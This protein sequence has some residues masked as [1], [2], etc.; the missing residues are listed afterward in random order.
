[1]VN[2]YRRATIILLI[3]ICLFFLF[4]IGFF[5]LIGASSKQILVNFYERRIGPRQILSSLSTK[6]DA[7][8]NLNNLE[9]KIL[10]LRAE[11]ARLILKLQESELIKEQCAFLKQ[12]KYNFVLS[13]IV[14][15]RTEAG[16]NWYIIN[17]GTKDNIK[18]GLA[19]I[20]NDGYLVGKIIKTEADYSYFLPIFDNHF[21]TSVD[22]LSNDINQSAEQKTISGLA[23]G[24]YGLSVEA[25]FI[26][27]EKNIKVGDLVVTSGLEEG[28]PRG[29][30][31]GE[32]ENIKK[33]PEQ[34]FQAAI[35]KPAISLED[36]RVVTVLVP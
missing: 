32:I 23:Q 31:L 8:S 33:N 20:A 7:I 35:I 27:L 19:V 13:N 25:D 4:K 1:M 17:F 2:R 34:P 3:I 9:N 29:L 24:K 30:I 26:P 11:N 5:R 22:F 12:E 28:I 18:E 10:Q 6:G 15:R 16:F 14:G 21:L 36:L